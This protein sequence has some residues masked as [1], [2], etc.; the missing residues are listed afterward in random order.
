MNYN[1][2]ILVG[3]VA[4]TGLWWVVH[5]VRHYPGPKVMSLYIYEDKGGVHHGIDPSGGLVDAK[6]EKGE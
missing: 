1:S 6:A 2:V 4:L 5:A 3:V